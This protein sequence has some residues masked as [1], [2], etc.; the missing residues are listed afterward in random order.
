MGRACM[1]RPRMHRQLRRLRG[2]A[3]W[4][5]R[6]GHS[7]HRILEGALPN[8]V[9]DLRRARRVGSAIRRG[10]DGVP[11]DLLRTRVLHGQ[12]VTCRG[13]NHPAAE[14]NWNHGSDAWDWLCVTMALAIVAGVLLGIAGVVR[15]VWEVLT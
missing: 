6:H 13:R 3:G 10:R 8:E 15:W 5:S 14:R 2:R 9:P 11:C 7:S 12:A 4:R 1:T